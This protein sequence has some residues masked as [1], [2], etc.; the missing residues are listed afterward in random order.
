MLISDYF[1]AIQGVISE[2]RAHESDKIAQ[3]AAIC[4]DSIAAGGVIHIHDTGHM[5]NSEL[6]HR[7]G[8]WGGLTPFTYSLNVNN[9]NAFR[10]KEGATPNLT[11]ETI[12]LALR[13]SNIRAGDVL[14]VGS[15]SGKSEA[16]VELALQ[17]RAMGVTVVAVTAIG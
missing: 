5:L 15:V 9:M 16:P 1:D 8:G 3:V 13:R 11:S 12:A 4:A 10:D 7:A 6:I 17:A 14:V 2:I